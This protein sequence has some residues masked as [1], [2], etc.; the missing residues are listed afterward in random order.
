M[1]AHHTAVSPLPENRSRIIG[2][3]LAAYWCVNVCHQCFPAII[4]S[5]QPR[6]YLPRDASARHHWAPPALSCCAP[7]APTTIMVTSGG[8]PQFSPSPDTGSPASARLSPLRF[9][10]TYQLPVWLSWYNRGYH[11]VLRRQSSVG[12]AHVTTEGQRQA[13]IRS[14]CQRKAYSAGVFASSVVSAFQ[15]MARLRLEHLV[16]KSPLDACTM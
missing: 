12:E 16:P 2:R 3:T 7:E 9:C 11:C 14:R 8:P 1:D 6:Q 13:I 4:S 5:H 15:W 10:L